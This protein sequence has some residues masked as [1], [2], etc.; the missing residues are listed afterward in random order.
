MLIKLLYINDVF[1]GGQTTK[2]GAKGT[3]QPRSSCRLSGQEPDAEGLPRRRRGAAA[4]SPAAS[5]AKAAAST[6]ASAT[7]AS[8]TPQR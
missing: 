1:V 2:G 3:D 5:A 4:A 7:A 6:P 8:A